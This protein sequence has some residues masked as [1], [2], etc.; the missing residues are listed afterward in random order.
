MTGAC[1]T[2]FYQDFRKQNLVSFTG[3]GQ[4]TVMF[5]PPVQKWCDA[6]GVIVSLQYQAFKERG[7]SSPVK[8]A[9]NDHRAWVYFRFESEDDAL[10]FRMKWL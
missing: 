6:T 7:A 2:E 3:F 1:I 9:G 5:D 8:I 10:L 4:W